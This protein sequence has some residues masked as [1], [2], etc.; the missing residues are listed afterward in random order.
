MLTERARTC[1]TVLAPISRVGAPAAEFQF[2]GDTQ[3][4]SGTNIR[5]NGSIINVA[6]GYGNVPQH[7]IFSGS[8]EVM[9]DLEN[10]NQYTYNIV[11]SEIPAS[12]NHR[13][14]LTLLYDLLFNQT[15]GD[16]STT[17]H[18][19]LADA[20]AKAGIPFGRCDLPDVACIG[21]YEV[22]RKNICEIA[23]ELCAPFNAFDYFHYFVRVSERDGLSIIG[24]DYT[25]A[26]GVDNTYEVQNVEN[27]TRT[28]QRYMPDSKIGTS[29]ILL[30]GA[31]MYAAAVIRNGVLF[32]GQYSNKQLPPDTFTPVPIINFNTVTHTY[33]SDSRSTHY[34]ENSDGSSSVD[35]DAWVETETTMEFVI[36]EVYA[37]G[38]VTLVTSG[39]LMDHVNAS[40]DSGQVSFDIIESYVTQ[41]VVRSYDTALGPIELASEEFT[42]NT[43]DYIKFSEQVYKPGE[44]ATHVLVYTEVLHNDYIDASLFPLTLNKT[45]YGYD[46]ATG[47]QTSRVT[48]SYHGDNRGNWILD[49]VSSED[50]VSPNMR[51]SAF[52]LAGSAGEVTEDNTQTF[53]TR[54]PLT[55]K[56][57]AL[58]GKYQLLDGA[59]YTRPAY[60]AFNPVTGQPIVPSDDLSIN[61]GLVIPYPHNLQVLSINSAPLRSIPIVEQNKN[62]P[63]YDPTASNFNAEQL[64][65]RCFQMSIPYMDFEGLL[66]IWAMCKKQQQLE[67]LGVYWEIVKTTASIDTTPAAGES[68]V[69]AGS[70][71]ICESVEHIITEDSAMTTLGIR[72]LITPEN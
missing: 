32:N 28:F 42:Y 53:Q 24:I 18:A 10:P 58:V 67:N 45:W 56:P 35:T 72:R 71:G 37:P 1:T 68:I 70:S 69:A 16:A 60:F 6:A 39:E 9:D 38:Q 20:C 13:I 31:D 30:V 44:L 5:P 49:D 46:P 57:A 2:P 11:L 47:A 52:K 25:Q 64:E 8:V 55:P 48:K 29:D 14:K 33:V 34:G 19:L 17:T 43:Y 65:K 26:G 22:I 50:S 62:L 66:L 4:L 3:Q 54:G 21:N 23:E 40:Q 15:L 51:N 36:R 27:K 59:G 61:P 12:Q 41:V 63:G 7:T